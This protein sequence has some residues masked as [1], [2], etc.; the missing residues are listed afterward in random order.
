MKKISILLCLIFSLISFSQEKKVVKAGYITFN[1][2]SI[3]EFKNLTIENGNATYFNE[4]SQT[5]T[6]YPLTSIKKIMDINGTIVYESKNKIKVKNV[7]NE[8]T[9]RKETVVLKKKSEKLIYK[10]ASKITLNDEILTDDQLA[11]VL[12]VEPSIYNQYKKGKNG[13]MLGSILIG[14]GIGFFIGS[15][16]SNVSL[17]N[18]GK[19]G[20]S[21]FLIVGLATAVVGIPVRLGGIKNI[22][23]AIE[24]YNSMPNKNVSYFDKSALKVIANANGIGFQLEF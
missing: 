2:N 13:A 15:G 7:T 12:K 11:T 18:N 23:K 24:G 4:V 9:S 21:A 22:K 8:Q 14:G 17:A 19:K 3:L 10:S 1:S 16:L 6:T 5:E 20:S